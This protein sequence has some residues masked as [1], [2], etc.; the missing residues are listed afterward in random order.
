MCVCV[1]VKKGD[2]NFVMY[3]INC[4]YKP[5][6]LETKLNLLQLHMYIQ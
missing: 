2:L 3:K 6:S 1:C 4:S 5:Y